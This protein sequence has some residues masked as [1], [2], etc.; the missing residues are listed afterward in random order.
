MQFLLF[1]FTGFFAHKEPLH[2]GLRG[3]GGRGGGHQLYK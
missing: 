1:G 3:E 2:P